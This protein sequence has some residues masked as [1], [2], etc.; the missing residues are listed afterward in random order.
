MG[1][2]NW[3]LKKVATKLTTMQS[4]F[5]R[6]TALFSQYNSLEQIRRGYLNNSDIYA[7]IR[8]IAKTA[9]TVPLYVYEVKDGQK[10]KQYKDAKLS[11]ANTASLLKHFITKKEALQLADKDNPLQKLIDNPNPQYDGTEFKEGFYTFRL[12][13]GNGYIYTLKYEFGIDKGK[14][15]EMHLMP[16]PY[17]QPI[18]T[19]DYPHTL[20]GYQMNLGSLIDFGKDEV[21]HSRYFNPDYQVLGNELVGV[22]PLY[23]ASKLMQRSDDETNYSVA[24]FQNSGISGIVYR[25]NDNFEVEKTS[26]EKIKND[27]Y[28]ESTGTRNAKKS[29]FADGKWGYTQVGLGPVDMDV[30]NSEI[31]TFKRLCNIYGVSDVLFNN[32]EAAT[33]SNVK[34]QIKQLYLN[35]ALPEVIAFRDA[36]N[37]HITP[38]YNVDGKQYFVDFDIS[39][40]TELQDDMKQLAQTFN[41]LPIMIPNFILDAFGYGKREDELLDKI[42]V[43]NGY[44]PIDDLTLNVGDLPPMP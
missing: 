15:Y 8:R 1:I 27:F 43:K 18:V 7:I 30:I 33:E 12:A 26:F 25:E 3:F 39:G 10:L 6:G 32:G 5:V 35:A 37:K 34:E 31:R 14:P 44:T 23:A 29:L 40:I 36:I 9:S 17:V 19:Q 42:Y 20:L 41:D 38:M 2:M 21:L 4:S 16:S 24:A 13:T 11:S 28:N 22:S